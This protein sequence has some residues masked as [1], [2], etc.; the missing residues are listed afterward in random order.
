MYLTN[1]NPNCFSK[2]SL[3]IA[4]VLLLTS[5]PALSAD[6]GESVSYIEEIIV[7]AEKREEN[8]LDVPLT[9]T[10]FNNRMIEE[11]GITRKD[12]L[13]QLV[14]GLQFGETHSKKGQ[15]TVIRGMGNREAGVLQGNMAV[16]TYVDGVYHTQS[17]AIVDGLF[18]VERVEVARGPQGT[19]NGRNSIAG[20]ISI[21]SKKPTYEWDSE[22]LAEFTNQFSQRYGVAFGGPIM[23]QFAFRLTGTYH[24]GDGAQENVGIGPDNDAPKSWSFKPQIRFKTDRIDVNLIYNKLEDTGTS[25]TTLLLGQ[26]PTDSNTI[27]FSWRDPFDPRSRDPEDPLF[28]CNEEMNNYAWYLYDKKVPTVANCP[29]NTTAIRCNDIKNKVLANRPALENTF[30]VGMSV[31]ADFDVSEAL[32]L[33]YSY[34]TTELD[35]WSSNDNDFTDRVPSAEDGLTPED[36]VVSRGLA[37]CQELLPWGTNDGRSAFPYLNDESSHELQLI[38]N[39]DGPLNFIVGVYDYEG[40]TRWSDA[41]Q[42][43]GQRWRT[44]SAD[45]KAQAL[46]YAD[47]ADFFA[48]VVQPSLEDLYG[49]AL[50]E[51]RQILCPPADQDDFTTGGGSAA[52]SEQMTQAVFASFDYQISEEWAVSGGLRYTE[53]INLQTEETDYGYEVLCPPGDEVCDDSGAGVPLLSFWNGIMVNERPPEAPEGCVTNCV[54]LKQ[55]WDAVIWNA[56]LEYTPRNNMLVYG[57]ISTGYRA[58]GL[59]SPTG[60]FFPKVDEETVINYEGGLKGLFMDDK[61]LLTASGYIN[62]YDGFQ[63]NAIMDASTSGYPQ[64]IGQFSSSP[65]VEFTT[66]VDGTSIFGLDLEATYYIDDHWRISGYYAWL[67]S[68]LGEFSTVIQDNPD[69][70]IAMWQHLDWDTGEFKMS[71][72]IKPTNLKDGSLPQS[73]K[74]K[75]AV[76]VTYSTPLSDN[77]GSL[78]L[79]GTWSYTGDRYAIVQ[80]ADSNKMPAYDR[81]DLR[82]AWASANEQWSATV[83]VQN[84]LDEIG[85]AE[86][87]PGFRPDWAFNA[88]EGMPQGLLTEPRQLGLQVRWKPEM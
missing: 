82:A 11:L 46:G 23:E 79:L 50:G 41:F 66:N 36:C 29:P 19:L 73:P 53:D 22:V 87:V 88:A 6:D 40:S 32:T 74:H 61:L 27:C 47:C 2:V 69:P 26:P 57:R 31:N 10:G 7:T 21:Y 59:P 58:G 4:A 12:D 13:E 63:I 14:P 1:S 54:G 33:R 20:S 80:N 65:L 42:G 34:G 70:E 76:T 51:G 44:G 17:V 43:F 71:P 62:D 78:Q 35:E 8:I 24:E 18:D 75:A 30:R 52:A 37:E 85:L 60:G 15:G 81:L 56:N 55:Q 86:Y 68:K 25:R 64:A 49:E 16:A 84:A 9:I 5:N 72:Y 77:L 67:D 45:S 48:T 83:Y 38:S 39:F 3:S 28:I